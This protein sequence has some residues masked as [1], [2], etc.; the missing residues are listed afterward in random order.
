MDIYVNG[1]S[2][3]LALEGRTLAEL[4][5]EL[6][7]RLEAAGTIIIAI[8]LNGENIAPEALP[9]LA[10]TAA[11]GPGRLDVH[12]ESSSSMRAGA[13]RTLIE[14]LDAIAQSDGADSSSIRDTFERYRSAF[15]GLY[16]AEEESFLVALSEDLAVGPVALQLSLPK[17]RS[18]FSERLAEIED[19]VA[20]MKGAARLFQAIKGD[21]KE[22]PVRMQ[23]G[24]DAEAM[25]CMMLTVELINKTVRLLPEFTKALGI[26][27]NMAIAGQSWEHFF[28]G[29]NDI[30]RELAGAFENKDG[31]LIGDLAEYEIVPRLEALFSATE[32]AIGKP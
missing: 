27:S 17:L 32:E 10:A 15:S 21:L 19:P 14:F 25:R 26:A 11:D 8:A 6:D 30:L 5:G 20:S 24:K 2:A 9:G 31:V 23:T 12:A 22:V 29:F 3:S 4:L 28:N 7:E 18:F 13:M 1:V 16:S